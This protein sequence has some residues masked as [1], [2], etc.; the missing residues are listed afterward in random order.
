MRRTAASPRRDRLWVAQ[1]GLLSAV[2]LLSPLVA[3][4]LTQSR[5]PEIIMQVLVFLACIVWV[6][7]A[8]RQG[9]IEL[10]PISLYATA[11]A[12]LVVGGLSLVRTASIHATLLDLI[13]LI[14][15]VSI[16]LMVS[17]L[18]SNWP[19][20]YGV[21]GA[22]LVSTIIVGALGVRESLL[23]TMPD[24]R[25]F[26]TFFNPDFLAGFLALGLPVALAWYLTRTSL[27]IS[28]VAGLAVV[29]SFTGL[30]LSGSRFGAVAAFGGVI[31]FLVPALI[32]GSIR[33]PQLAR[34]GIVLIPCI[35]AAVLAGGTLT[36]RV[37][38]VKAESHSGGF[39]IYTWKG[40]ARIV[41]HH[42]VF[43]TGLGTFE[44]VYPKYA[45]VGWTRLAHNSYLQLAAEGG[46]A[47]PLVLVG[48]IGAAVVPAV[49]GLRRR[50]EEEQQS[51]WMPDRLLMMSGLLGGVA[52][53][54]ARNLVDS[55]WYVAAIGTSFWLMLGAL[56]AL[57]DRE[58]WK[59]SVSAWMC[60]A[61]ATALG[62]I[63]V[64]LLS[65]LISQGYYT[66]AWALLGS[67]DRESAV[68]A[69]RL[70]TTFD[71]L[72]ADLHRKLGG[73]L[74]LYSEQSDDD[75]Y[76]EACAREAERELMRAAELEPT[77]PKTHYQ[78][79][80]LYANCLA[81]YEKAVKAYHDA[82]SRDPH[83]V[84]V[85]TALAETYGLMGRHSDVLRAY[86]R[87]AEMEDSVYERVR[88]IPE[89]V[90]P[91]YIF[92]HEAL[93]RD[94][95]SRGEN[96][97]AREHYRRALDRIA[98]YRDSV[99]KM[100]PVMEQMGTRDAA[101]EERVESLRAQ[102]ESRLSDLP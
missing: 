2:V 9:S 43:G 44:V 29:L 82:L 26:S 50:R 68:R 69:F 52:A 25:V 65:V 102:I 89:L 46:A 35:V 81:D 61:K 84:Q 30:L 94:A 40:T 88:A 59:V 4:K 14:S 74:R 90:E 80:K 83:A 17:S 31:V 97:R 3:G 93:G 51:D 60:R 42:P 13:A 100:G 39:R 87:V 1:L 85:Y 77:A 71:P 24:W 92:A 38:S 95:E 7:R 37:A 98:R 33:R 20:L 49:A 62:L 78:L 63:V 91:S 19:A 41:R 5:V 64:C 28:A 15:Y 56:V 58:P 73:V 10:P 34:V 96:V 57:S 45:E 6:V 22:L 32:S 86:R 8:G 75:A 12:L 53:S 79:G 55:D 101:L 36:N 11:T 70:A 66:G 23:T 18:R 16:F 76:A 27:G 54:M 21:L 47:M 72:N 67:G 48:L 99:E